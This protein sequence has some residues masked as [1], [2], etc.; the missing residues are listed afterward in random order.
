MRSSLTK[1]ALVLL[2]L[3]LAWAAPQLLAKKKEKE[4]DLA[5]SASEQKR[6]VHALNRLTF[7]PRPGDLQQVMAVG[8]DRWIDLQLHPEKIPDSAMESRLAPFR[9]LRMSS[10]EMVEEFPDGQMI[11]QVMDGKRSMPSDPAK[12]AVF[13]VQIARLQERKEE[14]K[15][16]KGTDA[17]VQIATAP[18]R[19]PDPSPASET[20]KTAEEIAAAAASSADAAGNAPAEGNSMNA[21]SM[22]SA[23]NSTTA[24]HNQVNGNKKLSGICQSVGE[25]LGCSRRRKNAVIEDSEEM[26]INAACFFC[27]ASRTNAPRQ[28]N[29]A[30]SIKLLPHALPV[31]AR[32]EGMPAGRDHEKAQKIKWAL[33]ACRFV[34]RKQKSRQGNRQNPNR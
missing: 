27:I 4:K 28:I 32:K 15:E 23:S 33:L 8:V 2:C 31:R 26:S 9:T 20:A 24:L 17:A 14:K 11:K 30:S 10:R 22:S 12:R 19:E 3:S 1:P 6:A 5:S 34:L 21:M 7:G 25:K 13:Q 29:P 16:R 18:R